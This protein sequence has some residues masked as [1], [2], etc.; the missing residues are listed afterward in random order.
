MSSWSIWI[1]LIRRHNFV[2]PVAIHAHGTSGLRQVG[3][4]CPSSPRAPGSARLVYSRDRRPRMEF[5]H[6]VRVISRCRP[7]Q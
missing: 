7:K 3:Q 6:Q 2:L 5:A 4:I 1:R